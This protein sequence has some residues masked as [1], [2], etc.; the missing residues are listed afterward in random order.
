MKL[1]IDA[2]LS[3]RLIKLLS[4]EF[5]KIDHDDQ[6]GLS[7]PAKDIEIWNWAL[8]NEAL[9]VTNDEDFYYF[10]LQKGFPPKVVLLRTGNQRTKAIAEILIKHKNR[11]QLFYEDEEY[12]LLELV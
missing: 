10:S 9:I 6:C 1:L 2:N 12:G 5:S 3:W 7:T 8:N 11:I 4:N